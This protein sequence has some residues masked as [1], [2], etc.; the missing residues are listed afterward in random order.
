MMRRFVIFEKV[1][2]MIPILR[3]KNSRRCLMEKKIR[4]SFWLVPLV[5]IVALAIMSTPTAAQKKVKLTY[6]T[7]WEPNPIFSE[8]LVEVG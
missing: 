7:W 3:I 1:Y 8:Y 4:R 6:W 2:I 5:F